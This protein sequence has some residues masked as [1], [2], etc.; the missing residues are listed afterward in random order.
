MATVSRDTYLFCFLFSRDHI[1]P[2]VWPVNGK[3]LQSNWSMAT[4]FTEVCCMIS[5]LLVIHIFEAQLLHHWI[6]PR[7]VPS[8][9][10]RLAIS[11]NALLSFMPTNYCLCNWINRKAS[12]TN[13]FLPMINRRL[14]SDSHWLVNVLLPLAMDSAFCCNYQVLILSLDYKI[15]PLRPSKKRSHRSDL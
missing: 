15:K 10:T 12:T 13:L 11:Q 4:D 8:Q 6:I 14:C 3:S 9:S 5:K 7:A 2:A 1:I